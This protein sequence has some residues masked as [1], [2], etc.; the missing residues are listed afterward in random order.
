MKECNKV[1][2]VCTLK[3]YCKTTCSMTQHKPQELHNQ[4]FHALHLNNLISTISCFYLSVTQYASLPLHF[5]LSVCSKST[6]HPLTCVSTDSP[7]IQ[8]SLLQ[9]IRKRYTALWVGLGRPCGPFP[10]VSAVWRIVSRKEYHHTVCTRY[11]CKQ[12]SGGLGT[13]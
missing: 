8:R 5:P 13:S 1:A 12:R 4:I 6:P 11:E 9:T 2:S 3:K 7:F 10:P